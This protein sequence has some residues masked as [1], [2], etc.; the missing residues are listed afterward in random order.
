MT[1]SAAREKQI[2][3]YRPISRFFSSNLIGQREEHD[4]FKE[5]EG[6]K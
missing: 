5:L 4:I 3:K 6:E 1:V 2:V